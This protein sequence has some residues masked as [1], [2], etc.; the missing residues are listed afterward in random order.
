MIYDKRYFGETPH[1][2]YEMDETIDFTESKKGF[3]LDSTGTER[4]ICEDELCS[5]LCYVTDMYQDLGIK[6]GRNYNDDA[7]SFTSAESIKRAFS[8]IENGVPGGIYVN[9]Q[10]KLGMDL[11]SNKADSIEVRFEKL[12]LM[13]QIFVAEKLGVYRTGELEKDN[14]LILGT[15]PIIDIIKKPK[16]KNIHNEYGKDTLK[17]DEFEIIYD[18]IKSQVKDAETKEKEIYAIFEQWKKLV[19]LTFYD[20]VLSSFFPDKKFRINAQRD[21]IN[22]IPVEFEDFV[23]DKKTEASEIGVIERFF[24]MLVTAR[25]RA[26]INDYCMIAFSYS[27]DETAQPGNSNELLSLF[28]ADGMT[29]NTFLN[30]YVNS[31]FYNTILTSK[32]FRKKLKSGSASEKKQLWQLILLKYI[33][34]IP[35][36]Q[37][38]NPNAFDY[39]SDAKRLNNVAKFW[40]KAEDEQDIKMSVERWCILFRELIFIKITDQS[41][42]TFDD[43][44]WKKSRTLSAIIA[45]LKSERNVNSSNP[46]SSESDN[47]KRKTRTEKAD[48]REAISNMALRHR[49][50]N[51]WLLLYSSPEIV[52]CR[53]DIVKHI[54]SIAENV[55]SYDTVKDIKSVNRIMFYITSLYSISYAD[56][57]AEE[58]DYDITLF[59]GYSLGFFN[60]TV[61]RLFLAASKIDEYFVLSDRPDELKEAERDYIYYMLYVYNNK[62]G[63][64]EI[65]KLTLNEYKEKYK[66]IERKCKIYQK[67][68]DTISTQLY[69]TEKYSTENHSTIVFGLDGKHINM[70]ISCLN[71]YALKKFIITDIEF[72][73]DIQKVLLKIEK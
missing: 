37:K 29:D 52:D 38:I 14:P 12:K 5:S 44:G 50:E 26:E 70:R 6:I 61:R 49:L 33:D 36:V 30:N 34:E 51:R 35:D 67:A 39:A 73:T 19:N 31:E 20:T 59:Y 7:E 65:K 43:R 42:T 17:A 23:K 18:N 72:E 58:F 41:I 54:L 15:I 57:V 68:R 60:K 66:I 9:I 25:I 11:R 64:S 48:R 27:E 47:T 2:F 8:Y 4:W 32:E 56:L 63:N 21:T 69:Y 24:I 53:N 46:K 28:S 45:S 62:E 13:K 55:F 10:N 40:I 71:S 16:L 3:V 1:L 22:R